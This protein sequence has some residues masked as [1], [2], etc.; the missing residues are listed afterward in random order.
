M[1][2]VHHIA[3]ANPVQ[4]PVQGLCH[5]RSDLDR[6]LAAGYCLVDCRCHTGMTELETC[7]VGYYG[8]TIAVLGL[9]ETLPVIVFGVRP[10]VA[11][12][13]DSSFVADA[14]GCI[15]SADLEC[16]AVWEVYD[17]SWDQIVAQ[18]YLDAQVQQP[19]MAMRW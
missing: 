14:L 10:I 6:H 17:N 2:S 13:L 8:W 5:G 11:V 1:A 7:S 18:V 3:F 16:S 19:E 4:G 9:T 12:V 15:R